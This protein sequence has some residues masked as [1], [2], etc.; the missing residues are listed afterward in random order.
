VDNNILTKPIQ[1]LKMVGPRRAHLLA[2]LNIFSLGDLLYHFPREYEDRSHMQPASRFPHGSNAVVKGTVVGS[3]ELRPRKNMTITKLGV[4]DGTGVF[5]AV[6]FNQAYIKKQVRPGTNIVVTGK[7]DKSFGVPQIK[8]TDFEKISTSGKLLHSG[9]IVPMYPLTE[10][11]GQRTMRQIMYAALQ[12]SV[13]RIKEFLPSYILEKYKL[14]SIGAALSKIHFPENLK[15]AENARKRLVFEELFLLQLGLAIRRSK[16]SN[17]KKDHVYCNGMGLVSRLMQSLPFNLTKAQKRVWD[18]ISSNMQS[19][20][21]MNRLLQ[22]DVG[23]GKTIICIFALLKAAESGLQGVLMAPTEILAEQHYIN[24]KKHLHGLGVRVVIVSGAVPAKEKN[25]ILDQISA[26]EANIVVGTHAVIQ[27]TVQFKNLS[28]V[29]VDE[30]HRFGVRQ[31]AILQRKGFTPDVLVMTATPIPRTLTMTVYGELDISVIDAL[32]PGRKPVKTYAVKPSAWNKVYKLMHNQIE[33]GHQAY[34]VC[35]LVEESEKVDIQSAVDT[36]ENLQK[37]IFPDYKVGLLHGRMTPDEKDKTMSS[38]REGNTNIL[39]ATSV[40]EVGVDVPNATVIII[41]DAHRFGLAQ[42]HQLRGRVGRG[43]RQS[44]CILVSEPGTDEAK[45]RLRAMTMSNDGFRLAEMDLKIRGPG[46]LFG[47]R[48]SG[49]P[50]LKIADL[51]TNMKTM[52]LARSEALS[53]M[54]AHGEQRKYDYNNL[55]GEM[56]RRFMQKGDYID[57]S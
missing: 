24:L 54:D 32:P 41:V 33:E 13:P 37:Q 57:I 19:S 39:V 27:E 7:M 55:F 44:Y 18:E 1:F 4:H 21:P 52:G 35:A 34:L 9:R 30:Q 28:L 25:K 11:L 53:F 31:R 14:P 56:E 16:L 50:E 29:V 22:G 6:W 49:L 36:A 45:E 3:E 20:F 43:A 2:K 5:F 42:L 26:G 15:Q 38:F 8:V 23:S 12:E 47:T 10:K 46:E 51:I 48:Q 40:I 17:K